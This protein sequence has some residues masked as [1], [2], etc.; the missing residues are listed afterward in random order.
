M[1][2]T[3]ERRDEGRA[4]IKNV[5]SRSTKRNQLLKSNLR[6]IV[7]GPIAYFIM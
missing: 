1:N 2:V 6:H 5:G 3:H 4:G 7:I